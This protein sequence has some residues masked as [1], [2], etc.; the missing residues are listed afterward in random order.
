[1]ARSSG[2]EIVFPEC[3]FYS[4]EGQ[5]NVLQCVKQ[6]FGTSSQTLSGNLRGLRISERGNFKT[7][8]PVCQQNGDCHWE[9]VAMGKVSPG[10]RKRWEGL[11][12]LQLLK[13]L[14]QPF[15][16]SLLT[17]FCQSGVRSPQKWERRRL[18]VW[19][20][21]AG[22]QL[23]AVYSSGEV[24]SVEQNTHTH[25]HTAHRTPTASYPRLS[26]AS[27]SAVNTRKQ[28][29]SLG[30]GE[31]NLRLNAQPP[32]NRP[33]D[34]TLCA[35]FLPDPCLCFSQCSF[36]PSGTSPTLGKGRSELKWK[37]IDFFL[38]WPCCSFLLCFSP[39]FWLSQSNAVLFSHSASLDLLMYTVWLFVWGTG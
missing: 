18:W 1:M 33:I 15:K 10:P 2:R 7:I 8:S 3:A 31:D 35:C 22:L 24:P 11:E 13:R 29:W 21:Q 39:S 16:E 14:V 32:S 34:I 9:K 27:S 12:K 36:H 25:T 38:E 30:Y 17:G 19:K 23:H 26:V 28:G 5:Y 6:L 37:V 4:P 20:W